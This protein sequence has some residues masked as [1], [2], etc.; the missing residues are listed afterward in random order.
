[1]STQMTITPAQGVWVVRAGGAVLAESGAAMQLDEDGHAPVIYFPRGDIAMAFLEPSATRTQCPH[2]G[3]AGYFGIA[4][5]TGMIAD[6]AWAYE[7]P[8]SGA[9]QIGG[10]VAFDTEMVTVERI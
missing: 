4:A 1:M 10:H 8:V 3:E 7:A 6:A 5:A 9:E 2:K